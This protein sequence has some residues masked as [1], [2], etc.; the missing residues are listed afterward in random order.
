MYKLYK[1]PNIVNNKLYIG[2]TKLTLT[3]RL[4]KHIKDSQNPK[5]PLHRAI[6][7]HGKDKFIIELIE[8]SD[9]R[10]YI[11][12]SEE[13]AIL[14]FDARKNGYNIATGGYGGDLGPE[15][16]AKRKKTIQNLSTEK[17]QEWSQNLSKAKLGKTK[18]NDTGRRTQALKMIDNKHRLNIPQTEET[19]ELI[20]LK[21]TGKIRSEIAI[22]NYQQ[23]AKLRGTGFQLQGKKISCICCKR[24]WDLGNFTQHI[25]RKNNEL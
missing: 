9:D 1:I 2:I 25:N 18:D 16:N 23:C 11:S 4:S 10:K 22:Q 12:E 6:A 13:P 15:A 17:K 14:R 20:S 5:Y 24:E 8:E 21:N 7:K 3:E 19:K